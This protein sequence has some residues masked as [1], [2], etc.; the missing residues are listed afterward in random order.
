[1]SRKTFRI[2]FSILAAVIIALIVMNISLD[3][4]KTWDVCYEMAN[5]HIEYRGGVV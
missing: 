4:E 5:K 3:N 1:M 2:L